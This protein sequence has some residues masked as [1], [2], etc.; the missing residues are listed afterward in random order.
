MLTYFW[1]TSVV[2]VEE[3]V[4][5]GRG[6]LLLRGGGGEEQLHVGV[7]LQG[8]V[9][10]VVKVQV[11]CVNQAASGYRRSAKKDQ[12]L[13]C[14][15]S[16]SSKYRSSVSTRLHRIPMICKKD[17]LL[18]CCDS[19]S[20][21]Y[22]SSVSTRLQPDTNDLQKKDQLLA[23]WD[24]AWSKYRSPVSTRL[25]LNTDDLQKCRYQF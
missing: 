20:S 1:P 13:A 22:R 9:Q 11:F 15:D 17:Q 14:W 2:C 7:P 23:C 8:R 5:K 21:K 4:K 12:L 6:E 19:A 24:S 16:S 18:A 3:V 10:L 25:H